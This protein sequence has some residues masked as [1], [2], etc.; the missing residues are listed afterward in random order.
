MTDTKNTQYINNIVCHYVQCTCLG[1]GPLVT[2]PFAGFTRIS[3][4]TGVLHGLRNVCVYIIA[5]K[6]SFM[7]F[8]L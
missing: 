2:L 6:I 5:V 1:W 4:Q 3:G 8:G 7:L